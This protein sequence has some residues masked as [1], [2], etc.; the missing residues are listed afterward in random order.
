[1][2][3]DLTIAIPV[4]N[5]APYVERCLNSVFSQLKEDTLRIEIL[6]IDDR[7]TDQSMAVVDSVLAKKQHEYK[8]R[9]V[10]HECNLGLAEARNTAIREASG[11]FIWFI[12]S[13]D[14]VAPNMLQLMVSSFDAE[15][16]IVMCNVSTVGVS[17]DKVDIGLVESGESVLSGLEALEQLYS[18]RIY[19]FMWNKI[20]RR[21]LYD[22]IVFPRGKIYEDLAVMGAIFARARKVVQRPEA[23]YYYVIRG[24]SITSVYKEN[25]IDLVENVTHGIN[26][27]SLTRPALTSSPMV[28]DYV[29]RAAWIPVMNSIAK[30]SLPNG[31]TLKTVRYVQNEIN[32]K[33]L[34]K[35]AA[36]GYFTTL[37]AATA[38]R[39]SPR[40]YMMAYKLLVLR[41]RNIR[42]HS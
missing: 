42:M 10:K 25:I 4:Y 27:V 19:A 5:V 29:V 41:K 39:L 34:F 28:Q 12:D 33:P 38:I 1:M 21:S 6:I 9:I 15:T 26:L 3:Y 7:S 23:L 20:I 31:V 14:Y 30:A 35:L 16:D 2:N 17:G 11:E 13:D 36:G 37:I 40:A 18:R 22:A 24:D 32:I 8:V